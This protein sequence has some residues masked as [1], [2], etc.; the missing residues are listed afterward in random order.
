MIPIPAFF[1]VAKLKG[2]F[3]KVT[4]SP[5]TYVILLFLAVGAGTYFYLNKSVNN[6]VEAAVKGADSAATIKT[7]ET[8]QKVDEA[9]AVVDEKFERR[10]VATQKEYHNVRTTI[11]QAA[12]ADRDAPASP[13]ILDTLNR[14]ERM[15]VGEPS[16]DRVPD[17]EVP[18]G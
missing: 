7:Y 6:Q 9:T 15:R 4:K 17:A 3:T 8:K 5:I 14:L 12:P 2:A 18:V 16:T 11:I 1:T 10:R 13:V